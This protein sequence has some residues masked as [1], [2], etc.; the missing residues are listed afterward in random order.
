MQTKYTINSDA[1]WDSRFVE[2]WESFQGPAQ[3]RF[4]ARLA[5]ENLPRWLIDQLQRQPLT[6]CDWGCAQGDGTDVW[7]S[8]VDSDRITGIDFSS[9][10]VDQAL[11]RYPAIRFLNE[12]WLAAQP[13]EQSVFDVVFS[14]NT[15]EHFHKPHA[16]LKSLCS[17]ATKALVLALPYRELDR[18]HEHFYTFLPDNIPTAINGGFKLVWSRVVDCRQISNTLWGGDQIVLVY[19][20]SDWTDALRL[21]LRDFGIEQSDFAAKIVSLNQAVTERDGQITSLNQ[22]VAERDGQIANLNQAVTERD[23]QIASLNQAVAERD[24]QI[25]SLNQA[26]VDRDAQISKMDDEMRKIKQS[27]S[28]RITSRLRVA[29]NLVISPKRTTYSIIRS[30]FWKLPAGL[31]Q[32]LHSPRHAFVRFVRGLPPPHSQT[33]SNST[34][35]DLSWTEFNEKVLSKRDHYKGVFIQELVIDWNVPLYQRPQHISAALGRLGYLVIYRTDNWAG[36]DVNGFREVSK[37]VWITNRYE[38]EEI[39]GCVRSLYSTAYANTPELL[40]KNGKRGR[41][42]YE[43]I[44]H[45]DPEIS[46]DQENIR[47]LL[48]LKNFAF[49]GGADFIVASARKLYE[50]AVEA[51]GKEKVILVPNGVDTIH[52]R[53][54]LHITTSIPE[55]LVLFKEKHKAIVGYFGALAPWLWYDVIAELASQRPDLGFVFIGPDYYGGSE[56][57]PKFENVLYLGTIDYK[58]LPAYARQFDVCFIPFKLGEIA[59][60]TSPLKLFEY[61]ALEKPVVVTSDMDE[62]TAYTEVFRGG[63]VDELT[64]AIDAALNVKDSDDFKIRLRSLADKNDWLERAKSMEFCFGKIENE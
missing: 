5:I 40:L 50:E 11:K 16:V 2:D 48:S 42:V 22:A 13:G 46:G 21:T 19:A 7:A 55:P 34:L 41:I 1:Y 49:G 23:G 58:I 45:I 35:S 43:Y 8:Y 44:D 3:S 52:Y 18:H 14:S 59:K 24:G 57:L 37:N 10:A 15:L 53:N 33:I 30:L 29:K 9:V 62:C 20:N 56:K 61:F 31:R 63:S 12:D 4:F 28:W 27:T 32:A 26:V 6:L 25:A 39:Q 36:D 38:V 60:T 47:R 64:V 54:P 51:V 17:R